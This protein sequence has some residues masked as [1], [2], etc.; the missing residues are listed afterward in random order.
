[1]AT[2]EILSHAER[3]ALDNVLRPHLRLEPVPEANTQDDP[4]GS[5]CL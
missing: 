4:D 5:H 1:M 3:G 2:S